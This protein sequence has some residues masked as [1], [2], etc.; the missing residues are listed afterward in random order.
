MDLF[1]LYKLLGNSKK[2]KRVGRGSGSGKGFH[3]TGKGTKGQKAR[4]GRSLPYGFEGGQVPLYKKLPQVVG[5]KN[6]RKKE[7]FT[8]SLSYFNKFDN[9]QT[10]TPEMLYRSKYKATPRNGVKILASGELEKKLTFSKF[11][12]SEAAKQKIEKAGGKIE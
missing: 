4:T 1:N 2:R 7:I 8:V 12:I 3:T 11:I 9:G 6:P 5:F 10:I